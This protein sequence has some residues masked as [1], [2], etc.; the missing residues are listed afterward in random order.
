VLADDA[1][2]TRESLNLRF[3]LHAKDAGA[4]LAAWDE[5]QRH[6]PSER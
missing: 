2:A 6:W 5:V 4:E 3:G 1:S